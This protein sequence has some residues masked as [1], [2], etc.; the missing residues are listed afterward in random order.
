MSFIFLENFTRGPP[1]GRAK[2]LFHAITSFN[3]RKDV[4]GI[5]NREMIEESTGLLHQTGFLMT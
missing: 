3:Y 5:D 4:D 1:Q 2:K